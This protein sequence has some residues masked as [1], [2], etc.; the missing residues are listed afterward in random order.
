MCIVHCQLCFHMSG[1][2]EILFVMFYFR[3]VATHKKCLCSIWPK[4]FVGAGCKAIR[5]LLEAR[6]H[7]RRT[8]NAMSNPKSTVR[9]A[10]WRTYRSRNFTCRSWA[11]GQ[12]GGAWVYSVTFGT[13]AQS[14]LKQS[15]KDSYKGVSR[16]ESKSRIGG[17]HASWTW[18]LMQFGHTVIVYVIVIPVKDCKSLFSRRK[19][20]RRSWWKPLVF[21][22]TW[23]FSTL[24]GAVYQAGAQTRWLQD[25]L[26]P[27]NVSNVRQ[28][29]SDEE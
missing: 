28:W 5:L 4:S 19:S 3:R 21:R 26:E 6:M 22:W 15:W 12:T 8:M 13:K 14:S 11:I 27:G 9:I 7:T 25:F 17:H 23:F 2:W 16:V 29:I 18:L 20:S 24:H 10:F 1:S